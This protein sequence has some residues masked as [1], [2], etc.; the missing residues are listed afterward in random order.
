MNEEKK[1]TTDT[2]IRWQD[3]DVAPEQECSEARGIAIID[4]EVEPDIE[5]ITNAL[6]QTDCWNG[7]P[8]VV[9]EDA[10]RNMILMVNTGSENSRMAHAGAQAFQGFV[11]GWRSET[12]CWEPEPIESL[13]DVF[14]RIAE[15]IRKV[16]EMIAAAFE[17]IAWRFQ[18]IVEAFRHTDYAAMYKQERRQYLDNLVRWRNGE[19]VCFYFDTIGVEPA[20]VLGNE[21]VLDFPRLF[22]RLCTCPMCEQL[23]RHNISALC[24]PAD[25]RSFLT[26]SR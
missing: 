9:T 17:N 22:R 8:L 11:S 12:L 24:T 15:G 1:K 26:R 19:F 4:C 10:P 14:E 13:A 25:R 16:G 18:R 5:K 6:E 7:F 2:K 20:D 3:L 21:F 23:S